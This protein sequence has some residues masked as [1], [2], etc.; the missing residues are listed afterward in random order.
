VSAYLPRLIDE[1]LHALVDELP[2]LSIIGARAVGKTTTARAF[3]SS[4]VRLDRAAE[5]AAFRADPDLALRGLAEPVLLDEWQEVPG[6]LGAVKRA[7]DDDPRPGRFLLSGSVRAE[8][9][10]QT[11]PGTGRVVQL[12][13]RGLTEREIE[14]QA[15]PMFLDRVLRADP[16]ILGSSHQDDLRSY[17]D[18]AL[19]GSFPEPALR[20][21]EVG[22]RAWLDGYVAQLVTRDAPHVAGVRSPQKVRR[23]LEAV[24]LTA[25]SV[26]NEVTLLRAADI[27]RA[28]A[29]SYESLLVDLQ[30]L[31]LVPAW[32]SN[33]I[34]RLVKMPKRYLSDTGLVA[35]IG[36]FSSETVLRDGDLL[37]RILDNF[38]FTQ[39]R[40]ECDVMD[41]QPQLHHL[42]NQDG[43]HEVDLLVDFGVKGVVGIEIKASSAPQRADGQ[44][45]EWLRDQLGDRFLAGV[46]LHTGP[47]AFLLSERVVAAPINTLWGSTAA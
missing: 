10:N 12:H 7:V 37:G 29:R 40:A 6:V 31:D 19:R 47:R 9:D 42:R 5:A 24:S 36:R 30:I 20:L 3:A 18:R 39:L 14:G 32:H 11:W 13:M 2:A 33:R 38:V 4:V 46:V 28:T 17:I 45:L 21:S 1:R 22:R 41:A 35:A 8:L 15:G 34:S 43:R 16:T 25:A 44:H 23:Y 26:T 27:N